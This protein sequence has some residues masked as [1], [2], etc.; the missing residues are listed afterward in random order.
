MCHRQIIT[1]AHP[2]VEINLFAQA[3][4]KY[5]LSLVNSSGHQS[6]AFFE[7]VPMYNIEARMELPEEVRSAFS[8]R[9]NEELPLWRDGE[10]SCIRLERLGLFDTVV[11]EL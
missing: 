2:Q 5:V 1:D 8:L 7:P 11:M 3:E 9:L 6:T 4:G 10:Y